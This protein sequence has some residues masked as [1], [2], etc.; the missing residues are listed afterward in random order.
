M[1]ARWVSR[2][3]RRVSK[4]GKITVVVLLCVLIVSPLR[5]L[6]FFPVLPDP[7]R[8]H[9]SFHLVRML[10]DNQHFPID[11]PLSHGREGSEH[12]S[13]SVNL[14]DVDKFLEKEDLF[15][16]LYA[17]RKVLAERAKHDSEAAEELALIDTFKPGMSLKERAQLMFTFDVFFRACKKHGLSFFLIEG[18]LLGAYRH[19][20]LIPWDDDIDIAINSSQWQKVRQVLGNI[21]GFTLYASPDSQW[22]F[23]LSD[24]PAFHDKPFKW[25]NLDLFFFSEHDSYVWAL[26]WGVKHHLILK[27]KHLLPFSTVKWERWLLPAPAC[28]DRFVKS[29]Y[30]VNMC[31][32]PGYVHKTNEVYYSF[33]TEAVDCS[34]LHKYYP[35]VFRHKNSSGRTMENKKIG[36]HV[37]QNI[38][39]SPP[40]E[41][42]F[43]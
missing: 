42:C 21:P 38:S 30:D 15:K 25:P 37:L 33:Q 40:P 2:T 5:N 31:A 6:L 11:A 32:T 27:R 18:S 12:V 4:F 36:E 34:R 1:T 39:V 22:K 28:Y 35:F 7:W 8:T 16:E 26:T 20:G 29:S 9:S 10:F 19:H 23:Y 3:W 17:Q 41:V 14:S 43:E 24:L 13:V